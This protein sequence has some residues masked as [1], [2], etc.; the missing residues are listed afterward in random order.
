MANKIL[1]VDD[2]PDVLKVLSLRLEKTG[3]E[4]LA[5]RDAREALDLARRIIPDLIVLDF[6]LP[7][8]N[9]DD[10]VRVMK[11]DDKLKHI[12]V[13]LISATTISLAEKTKD[14]GAVAFIIKP[15]EPEELVG[16]VRKVLRDTKEAHHE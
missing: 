10:V 9:G 5:A 13:I 16:A 11:N 4:V 2:E 1:I 6:Y 7:D 3:Y 8:M 12:P 14:C 15:F